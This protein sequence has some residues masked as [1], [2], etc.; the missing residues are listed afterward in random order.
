MII[1][2]VT[3]T[4]T[5]CPDIPPAWAL[6]VPSF[7]PGVVVVDT[8]E[9]PFPAAHQLNFYT[10]PV[11][12]RN[13][14]MN[15][16]GGEEH[17]LSNSFVCYQAL[18]GSPCYRSQPLARTKDLDKSQSAWHLFLSKH[19]QKSRSA[20]SLGRGNPSSLLVNTKLPANAGDRGS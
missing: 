20:L 3:P 12:L 4:Q 6:A 2:L 18:V 14:P 16:F 11:T 1:I 19:H 9:L 5:K 7:A 17:N 15:S 8:R 13:N 10:L